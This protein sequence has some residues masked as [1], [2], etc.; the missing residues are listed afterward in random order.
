MKTLTIA[1]HE[2]TLTEGISYIA[3]RPM[4]IRPLYTVSIRYNQGDIKNGTVRQIKGLTYDDAND[5]INA[6]NNDP[7][8]SFYGREW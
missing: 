3:S 2:I 8:G 5:L 4:G 7:R 6:F 1:S